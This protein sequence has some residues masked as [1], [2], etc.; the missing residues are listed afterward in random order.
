MAEP[1]KKPDPEGGLRAAAGIVPAR[2]PT[3]AEA[4]PIPQR[5]AEPFARPEA[6]PGPAPARKAGSL[7]RPG[8]AEPAGAPAGRSDVQP[9][10]WPAVRRQAIDLLRVGIWYLFNRH[11]PGTQRDIFLFGSRRSGTTLLMEVLAANR[12]VKYTDQPFSLHTATALQRDY[13]VHF[14]RG[15][16]LD[17]DAEERR[18]FC[19]YVEDLRS[20]RLHVNENSRFWRR[21]YDRQT[22]RLVFKVTD[23]PCQ[24]PLVSRA[25]DA[26]VIVLF[27]HPISQSLSCLRNGWPPQP[28]VFLANAW[29]RETFLNAALVERCES[30][31]EGEDAL[32]RHVLGW[33]LENLAFVRQLPRHREWWMITYEHFTQHAEAVIEQ[34]SAPLDLPDT[35]EMRSLARRPSKSTRRLSATHRQRSIVRG[36]SQAILGSWRKSVNDETERRLMSIVEMFG[37]DLYRYGDVMPTTGWRAATR[38]EAERA[39]VRDG[40]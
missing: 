30:I 10:S 9:V 2:I 7:H 33:C 8:T 24:A 5:A 21:E 26:E 13:L 28:R 36:D 20:G 19:A 22:D 11:R 15:L 40:R 14:N 17:L 12:G 6:G 16:V 32:A 37:I 4:V 31:L 39:A 1:Q 23:A 34:W 25:L 3:E 38:D 35:E 27:R 29:F 18:L